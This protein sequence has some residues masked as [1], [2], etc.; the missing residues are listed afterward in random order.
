MGRK[1]KML[2]YCHAMEDIHCLKIRAFADYIPVIVFLCKADLK[3]MSLQTHTVSGS[4]LGVVA[5]V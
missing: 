1:G 2:R 4:I 5:G 3:G